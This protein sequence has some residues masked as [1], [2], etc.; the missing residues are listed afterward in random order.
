VSGD[1][2]S[3]IYF[4]HFPLISLSAFFTPSDSSHLQHAKHDHYHLLITRFLIQFKRTRT[5]TSKGVD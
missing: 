2:T 5:N 3:F 4:L 1:E